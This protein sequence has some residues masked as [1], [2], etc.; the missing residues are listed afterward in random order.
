MY[1]PVDDGRWV[2]ADFE[3]LARVIKDYDEN[4]ELRWIPP[5]KRTRNDKK[6]YVIVDI[7]LN[8][9]VLY[10]SELDTPEDI[11]A[12]LFIADNEKGNVLSKIDAYN[13][14]IKAMKMK[15]WLDERED[16]RDQANFLFS[17]PLN[18]IKFNG[19][20]LDHLRRPIL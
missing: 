12:R 4:L 18:T 14:A 10:A 20:K 15:E 17:S 19:K 9:V 2:N 6:P 16:M 5:D 1:I 11:L 7:R 13:N 8:E 3:R